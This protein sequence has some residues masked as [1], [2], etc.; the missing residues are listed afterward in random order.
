MN[1]SVKYFLLPSVAQW[2]RGMIPALGA[3]GHGF[4]SRL[5]QC[6]FNLLFFFNF[7]KRRIKADFET[8]GVLIC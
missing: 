3:V 8:L 4:K 1:E 7:R 5:S 2:S 6:N